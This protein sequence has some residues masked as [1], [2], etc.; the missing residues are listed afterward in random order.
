MASFNLTARAC[1]FTRSPA[2]VL[3]RQHRPLET[4]LA[5]ESIDRNSCDGLWAAMLDFKDRIHTDGSFFVSAALASGRAPS[6]FRQ[7]RWLIEVN[8][9][10]A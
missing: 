1:V 6:G 5:M 4:A 10:V 9:D 7:R 8:R 2:G 3:G